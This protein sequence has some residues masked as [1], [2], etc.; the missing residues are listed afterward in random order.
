LQIFDKLQ[1]VE[2]RY[3]EIE[4]RLGDPELA[5]QPAEFRRLSQEHASLEELIAEFRRYKV[6]QKDIISNKELLAG[7]DR[8]QV[9]PDT[10]LSKIANPRPLKV[11]DWPAGAF[12]QQVH[13]AC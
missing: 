3:L 10:P 12:W 9:R 1:S 7:K 5:N 11:P 13:E 8:S 4:S 6:L 2:A